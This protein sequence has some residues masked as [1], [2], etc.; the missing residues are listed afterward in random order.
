MR[1]EVWRPSF[2]QAQR[3]KTYPRVQGSLDPCLD[4]GE[5]AGDLPTCA[6]K[7]GPPF[8][9]SGADAGA[10]PR[11]QRSLGVRGR[12]QLGHGDLPTCAEEFVNTKSS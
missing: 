6:E 3:A 8:P 1:R 12:H 7:F 5:V 10:Y 4:G 2:R 11:V 9:K